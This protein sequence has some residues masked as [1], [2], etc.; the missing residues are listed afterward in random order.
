MT[1]SKSKSETILRMFGKKLKKELLNYINEQV[2][3]K[4]QE[5]FQVQLNS[6][7]LLDAESVCK[8][9]NISKSTLERYI[10][11]GLPYSSKSKGYKRHF[12][13]KDLD[14]W[15]DNKKFNKFRRQNGKY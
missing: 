7:N 10:R 2:E 13:Q 9:Y 6:N 4:F 5:H 8:K 1:E 12:K 11:E 3:I 15:F 14:I